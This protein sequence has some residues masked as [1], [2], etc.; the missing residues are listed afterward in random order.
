MHNRN[1]IIGYELHDTI[2]GK[3]VFICSH[4]GVQ[5]L[6]PQEWDWRYRISANGDDYEEFDIIEPG[7]SWVQI[8]QYVHVVWILR[9]AKIYWINI[10][11]VDDIRYSVEQQ[12]EEDLF[13]I[14]LTK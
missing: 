8:A 5:Y 13:N 10:P 14:L 6:L 9:G 4:I 12:E 3:S 7:V 11:I 1:E 2:E